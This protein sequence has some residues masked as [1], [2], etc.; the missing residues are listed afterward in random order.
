MGEELES[1]SPFFMNPGHKLRVALAELGDWVT[2]T[3]CLSRFF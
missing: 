3:V 1:P 2:L